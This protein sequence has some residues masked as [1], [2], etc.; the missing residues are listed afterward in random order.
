MADYV[1]NG[2]AIEVPFSDDEAERPEEENDEA[3][4]LSPAEKATRKERR[5]LRIKQKLDEGKEAKAELARE[6]AEAASLRERLARLEGVVSTQQSQRA[7]AVDPYQ[8]R[9]TAIRER[10]TREYQNLQAEVQANGG[11]LPPER[12]KHYV[13]VSSE[14][15]DEKVNIGV[16]KALAQRLPEVKQSVS[17]QTWE[18]KYPDVYRNPN[19][20]AYAEATRNRRLALGEKETAEL[21]D[22]V[23]EETMTALKLGP[24]PKGPTANEKAR[25]SGVSSSSNG[26]GNTSGG[27]IQMTKELRSMALAMYRGEKGPDGKPMTDE[28]ALKK[29]ADTAGKSL[30]KE[31]IL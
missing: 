15:E 28:Q 31:K 14:I 24:K 6:R 23:M 2:G 18:N 9:M 11:K 20:Y 10:Q 3:P 12:E 27:G 21:V 1:S 22:E 17:R 19:A 4:G 25:M 13:Q 26:G 8:A 7:P 29:W 30:R 5:T 16:E